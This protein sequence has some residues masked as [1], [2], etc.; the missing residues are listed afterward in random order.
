MPAERYFYDSELVVG[1]E[2]LLVGT[3]GQ[4]LVRVM[5]GAVGDSVTL[6]DGQGTLAEGE[7]VSVGKGKAVVRVTSVQKTVQPTRHLILAQGIPRANK[8]EMLLEKVTELGVT[9]IWLFPAVLSE[10]KPLSDQQKRRI[11]LLVVGACKQSGRLFLPTIKYCPALKKWDEIP[12]IAFYG[13]LDPEAPKIGEL[14]R[15]EG[16][17]DL[18]FAVGPES[19]F[20]KDEEQ[21]LER[22]GVKGVTLHHNVLR[23]ETAAITA[24]AILS[25]LGA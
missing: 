11:Q 13:S 9:D 18:L 14:V 20:T 10:K 7:L 25:H 2:I 16:S 1:I 22:L 23:T 6:F 3:E 8:L 15:G 19:G 5:R 17:A 4:H 24:I 21:A 12:G